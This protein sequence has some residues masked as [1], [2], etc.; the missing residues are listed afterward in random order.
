MTSNTQTNN[1]DT[2]RGQK[3]YDSKVKN[4]EGI[5]SK[6]G[7]LLDLTTYKKEFNDIINSVKDDP[8][9]SN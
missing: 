2:T 1:I 9:F 7:D 8:T 5:F 3:K 6:V 4:I